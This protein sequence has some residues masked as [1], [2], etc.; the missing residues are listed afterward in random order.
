[1]A[2]INALLED[3]GG[4]WS[5]TA[6]DEGANGSGRGGGGCRGCSP[7]GFNAQ[8]QYGYWGNF[9]TWTANNYG[10]GYT[11]TLTVTS[12]FVKVELPKLYN[13]PED[14][15]LS[16][17]PGGSK[18][19]N[20]HMG[21]DFS[22]LGNDVG[23]FL[24]RFGNGIGLG[25]SIVEPAF[26]AGADDAARSLKYSSSAISTAKLI[27]RGLVGLNVVLTGLT[28]FN[29]VKNDKFDTHSIV[30]LTVTT[31]GTGLVI[32]GAFVTAP[33]WGTAL[34]ISGTVIGVGYSIAQI[35]GI[36]DYIDSNWSI[37]D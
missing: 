23:N 36:N 1:M 3:G 2:A 22:K 37:R 33:V 35:A 34:A 20:T 5:R 11:Q 13:Y 15:M 32:A 24:D 7:S 25:N 14:P 8:G 10:S 30:N 31:I 12:K 4:T 6:W 17:F 26:S 19:W 29:E 18:F 9:N 28:V 21:R 16:Q 27:G